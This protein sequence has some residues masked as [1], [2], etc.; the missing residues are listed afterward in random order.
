MVKCDGT[1]FIWGGGVGEVKRFTVVV[2]V[3]KLIT[4]MMPRLLPI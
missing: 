4:G 3:D 1:K 2:D